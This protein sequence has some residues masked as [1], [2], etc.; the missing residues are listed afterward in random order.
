MHILIQNVCFSSHNRDVHGGRK[1]VCL[2][3]TI[4]KIS[5]A[6]VGNMQ[7]D[8]GNGYGKKVP[9]E[10]CLVQPVFSV[11]SCEIFTILIM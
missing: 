5:Y 4:T 9:G 10:D 3:I 11:H 7:V 2:Y 1:H 6:Y 8:H